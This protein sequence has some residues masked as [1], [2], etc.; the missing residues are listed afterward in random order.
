MLKYRKD[1]PEK[2]TNSDTFHAVFISLFQ[3]SHKVFLL[4]ET[5][6]RICSIILQYFKKY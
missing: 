3:G 5:L 2:I 4:E 6:I 1:R